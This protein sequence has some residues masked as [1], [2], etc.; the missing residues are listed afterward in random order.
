M[1]S[2]GYSR[3]RSLRQNSTSVCNYIE[4]IAISFVSSGSSWST[5]SSPSS[6]CSADLTSLQT[7]FGGSLRCLPFCRRTL[8]CG[9][10]RLKVTWSN[11]I[12]HL[13]HLMYMYMRLLI[14]F[15]RSWLFNSGCGFSKCKIRIFEM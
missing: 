5:H 12:A 3:W 11:F 4:N 1:T 14:T 2:S 8:Y 9:T 7:D 15:A 6:S 10:L 13:I